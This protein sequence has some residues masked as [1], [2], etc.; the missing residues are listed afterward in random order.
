MFCI[1]LEAVIDKMGFQHLPKDKVE[2][3][4]VVSPSMASQNL[5]FSISI[6]VPA[7]N[8]EARILDSMKQIIEYCDSQSWDYEIIVVE[9]GSKD[10][11]VEVMQNLVS[12]Y[13]RIKLISNKERLGKGL[14]IGHGVLSAGKKH[15]AYMD[16]DLSSGPSELDRLSSFID[17][18]DIVIGSRILRGEL[19]PIKRPFVRS[20]LSH[21]YSKLFRIMFIKVPIHDTQCGLKMFKAN[22]AQTLL[23]QIHTNGFAFDCEVLVKASRLGLTIKEVPVI[24]E[25]K[26]GS[27]VSMLHE[28]AV[29][30]KDLFS[31][32]Y[33]SKISKKD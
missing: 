26:Y 21:C 12:K 7:H 3:L 19:P 5:G 28:I 1:L 4:S 15:I 20:F 16:A 31:V 17:Q 2:P 32:W 10:R 23:T 30:S 9:D 6:I 25:H 18:F 29:M 22:I 24:W 27:K 11:T 14:A 33:R 13:E 8:E